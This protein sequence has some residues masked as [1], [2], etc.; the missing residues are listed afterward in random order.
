MKFNVFV[1]EQTLYF[2]S[3][4]SEI[5]YC[6]FFMEIKYLFLVCFT[7]TGG[8]TGYITFMNYKYWDVYFPFDIID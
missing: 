6:S 8:L 5:S 3:V 7:Y 4:F 2:L 1:P